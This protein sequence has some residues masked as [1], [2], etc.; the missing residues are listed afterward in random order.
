VSANTGTIL[1]II[2]SR[3]ANLVEI[4]MSA[5]HRSA[6]PHGIPLHDILENIALNRLIGTTDDI[7]LLHA[8]IDTFL[9][10][11]LQAAIKVFE[12]GGAARQHDVVV[13]FYAIRDRACLDSLVNDLFYGLL[14]ILVDEFLKEL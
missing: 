7:V 2:F 9:K 12:K 6:E 3:L 10:L 5:Q 4:V 14:P 8:L 13:E 11:L 1:G